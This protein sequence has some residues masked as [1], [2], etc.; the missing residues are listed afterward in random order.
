MPRRFG[1]LPIL[2]F[3]AASVFGG[4]LVWAVWVL[5][6]QRIRTD[7][8]N[9]ADIAVDRVV[10]RIEKHVVLLQA[11]R[12]L[13]AAQQGQIDRLAFDRFLA[14]I[15]TIHELGG[16]Q[17]IG[18]ARMIPTPATAAT[19]VEIE[20][21][22]RVDV[23]IRPPTSEPWRAPIVMIGPVSDRNLAAL[24]FDMYV[25][26]TRQAA[27]DRAIASG[28]PQM[29]GPVELVQEITQDKQTG[30]LIYLAYG[31]GGSAPPATGIVYAPF[32]GGDLVQAALAAGPP[33]AVAVTVTD[34]GAPFQPI[35][36]S[37]EAPLGDGLVLTRAV[38]LVG[39][40]W[41]FT[42][43]ELYPPPPYRRHLG[44]ILVG[45]IS[46]LFAGAAAAAVS[47]RQ[48]EAE[49]ARAV[50]AAAKR[51]AEY[52]GLLLNEMNH[53]IKNHIARIQSIAR[54]SARGATDVKSFTDSFDARLQAMAAVQEILVGTAVPQADVRAI[55]R[56]ELRQC[57]DTDQVEH[58]MD[59]PS[60]RL[61][62]RQAHAFAMVAHELVTNAMKYGGLASGGKGLRIVW[63][64][65]PGPEGADVMTVDWDER[66][67][68]DP[69]ASDL[70]SGF[71][72]R[73]IDASVKGELSGTLTRSFHKGGMQI[74]LQFP[75]SPAPSA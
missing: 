49:Q 70:P 58:L 36:T 32:R 54:Q 45:V 38:E 35:Y 53:R 7:F 65:A 14:T 4:G 75:L 67:A 22:Y 18:F 72:S 46:V 69:D 8:E 73:L 40:Q 39:R 44:S 12:G 33:L 19:E 17:G 61:D 48:H 26:P 5:E 2:A 74:R 10:T 16:V 37:P 63:Q 28:Q 47:A 15:D 9:T 3:L 11:T 56:T 23:Q 31:S 64:V 71:G 25:D 6:D 13:I 29:S 27:M 30:F 42:I 21:R 66:F 60:V 50:A 55:L 59:G 34:T 51:E 68:A 52:R 1:A 57:L 62:E 24:G 43:Q 20:D 41:S